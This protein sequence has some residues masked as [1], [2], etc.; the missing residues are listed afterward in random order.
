MFDTASGCRSMSANFPMTLYRRLAL[1]SR[2]IWMPKSNLSMTSRAVSEKPPMYSW[3]ESA[4]VSGS[5]RSFVKV[6]GDVL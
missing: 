3:S 4:M 2:S 6:S 5:S 1:R